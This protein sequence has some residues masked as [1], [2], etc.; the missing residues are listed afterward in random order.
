[1]DPLAEPIRAFE[2][3]RRFGSLDGLRAFAIAEVVTHH[4]GFDG[5]LARDSIGVTVFFAI[6]G[7]A[8][9]T[10]L[11]RELARTGTIDLRD[12]YVRRVLRTW[13]LYFAVLALY[14]LLVWTVESDVSAKR[15][16]GSNLPY[17]LTFTANWFVAPGTRVIFYFAWSLALQEQ[18]YAVAPGI[19][20]MLRTRWA[21]AV[22]VGA[23]IVWETAVW[24]EGAGLVRI[25]PHLRLFAESCGAIVL[26][27]LAARALHSRKGIRGAYWIA[28]RSWSGVAALALLGTSLALGGSAPT[29]LKSVAITWLIASVVIRP[30]HTLRPLLEQRF[31]RWVGTVSYGIYLTHMLAVNAARHVASPT[32]SPWLLAALA[33]PLSVALA[34]LTRRFFEQRFLALRDRFSGKESASPTATSVP[35]A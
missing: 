22:A 26:G 27:C 23:L 3:A 4:A 9:T 35:L 31:V 11:L 25:G 15:A 17:Y 13:P 18:F 28:G 2:R 1:M 12:F 34:G 33:M 5:P 7:F 19:V 29:L 24:A 20:R 8:I 6:S 30:D 14:V 21:A 32:A 16:F 10:V